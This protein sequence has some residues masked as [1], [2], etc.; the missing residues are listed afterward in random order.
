MYRWQELNV[1]Q[2]NVQ[3]SNSQNSI[4][5]ESFNSINIGKGVKQR[6]VLLPMLFN[7]YSEVLFK[8]LSRNLTKV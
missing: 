8:K 4:E 6:C 7:L 3:I 5:G 1:N 2:K